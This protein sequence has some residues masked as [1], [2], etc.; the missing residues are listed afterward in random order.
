MECRKIKTSEIEKWE[1]YVENNPTIAWQSYYWSEVVSR[2]YSVD[3]FPIAAFN[4][5]DICGIMPLY[6]VKTIKGKTQ[7]ISVPYAVGGGVVSDTH[8]AEEALVD[9]AIDLYNKTKANRIV[10]KQY[11]HKLNYQLQ[12]DDNFYNRELDLTRGPDIIFSESAFTNKRNIEKAD[13]LDLKIEYPSDN[14]SAFYR[15]LLVHHK[16]NGV[17]CVSKQWI[18]DLIKFKMYNIALLTRKGRPIATTLVKEHKFSV[19]FPFTSL[20]DDSD[21]SNMFAYYLYWRLIKRFSI[22]GKSFFHSGRIPHTDET[23]CYRLGWGGE[24]YNYYYQYYPTIGERSE[25]SE[26]KGRKRRILGQ[27]WKKLPIALTVI[28]GPKI[29]RYYP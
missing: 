4:G 27:L 24:K 16:I 13:K 23:N 21:Q 8:A 3:F 28:L 25:F 2:H 15:L 12:T 7:L 26:K 1:D 22:N 17:P 5:N 9:T 20:P 19:S 29:V 18:R 14:L 10:F 6:A 11:K